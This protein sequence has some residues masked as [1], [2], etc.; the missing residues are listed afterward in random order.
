MTDD[1]VLF[2]FRLRLFT[3]A[4]ELGN[5]S[6]GLPGD[7]RPPLDLL[8]AGSGRSTAG[9]SRRCGSGSAGGRGCRTRSAPTSSSGSSPSRSATRAS[10]RGG[11]RP[12]CGGEKW[13][14][15]R[16]S[17]HGVWRVLRRFSLNTRSKRL[18]LDRPPPRP[19]RAQARDPA[20]RAPHRRLRA[21]REGP[22]RL[23]L[24]RPPVGHQ[25]HRLAIHRDRRR[26]RLRLGRA[27]LLRAQPPGPPTAELCPPGRPRAQGGRLEAQGGHHRQRL[28]VPLAG[29]QRR[30]RGRRRA[31]ALHQGR[32][33]RTPTAA[34]SALQLTILEECWRPGL[35]PLAGAQ[36]HRASTRPR[37]VPPLLQLRPRP[38][39]PPNQGPGPRR[40]RLRRP[41]DG[42]GEM[43][44]C[45]YISGLG[46]PRG[47]AF[48]LAA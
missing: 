46:R 11:S 25:G 1:D 8:P 23:L 34:S 2:G 30:G 31:P 15:I 37:R 16:I 44:T 41:Q 6:A 12:S 35:R 18:A 40:Y 24:R 3:L 47:A 10:G 33:A 13:G 7:G 36:D 14:G 21:R 4:E 43:S 32:A 9:G 45:R 26:L 42:G 20:A 29:V 39:R 28:R 48:R 5:V 17:E 27:A 38:H 19:L 22:A